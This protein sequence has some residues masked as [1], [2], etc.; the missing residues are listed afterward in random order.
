MDNAFLFGGMGCWQIYIYIYIS[1]CGR[2]LNLT[3]I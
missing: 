3:L 2:D 1:V